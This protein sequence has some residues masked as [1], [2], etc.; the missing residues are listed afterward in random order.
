M[1]YLSIPTLPN[2]IITGP[3][4]AH[5]RFIFA[6]GAGAPMTHPW[7][8]LVTEKLVARNIEV[9]R[10]NFPYM[11][12]RERD[13]SKRP[14]DRA[15]KLLEC[16]KE[17]ILAFNHPNLI[18]GGK[19]MGGRMASMIAAK[20]CI[21]QKSLHDIKGLWCMGYPFHAPKKPIGTRMDHFNSITIPTLITQGERDPFGPRTEAPDWSLPA[22][23]RIHWASDG[24]HGLA[25]RKKSGRTLD[26]NLDDAISHAA[27]FFNF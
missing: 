12:Q 11:D 10:F 26:K 24:D 17:I 27:Q 13:S 5:T 25:P 21:N 23:F 3:K 7:M 6:H 18:I 14:P 9:V 4:N 22:S 1:T 20:D 2:T 19:S 15:P 8:E 16:F